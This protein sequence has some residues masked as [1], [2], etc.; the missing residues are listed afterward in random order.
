MAERT[1]MIGD[2]QVDLKAAGNMLRIYKSEFKTD[3]LTAIV[4]LTG[5]KSQEGVSKLSEVLD[6]EIADDKIGYAT[7]VVLNILWTFAKAADPQRVKDPITWEGQFTQGDLIDAAK[8]NVM[9]LLTDNLESLSDKRKNEND[10]K[11]TIER[12]KQIQAEKN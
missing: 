7:E 12:M 4:E 11:K 9:E 1:V 2:E 3:L 6:D 10:K 5:S 8:D